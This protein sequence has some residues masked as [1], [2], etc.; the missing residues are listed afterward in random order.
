MKLFV[1]ILAAL[2]VCAHGKISFGTGAGSFAGFGQD[3]KVEI[4]GNV[5]VVYT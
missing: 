1:T 2:A 4:A 3:G 5:N